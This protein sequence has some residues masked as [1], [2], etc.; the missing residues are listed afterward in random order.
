MLIFKW[1][2]LPESSVPPIESTVESPLV[3][4]YRT[5]ITP[6]FERPPKYAKKD[7]AKD[8]EHPSWLKIGFNITNSNSTLDIE[9][10]S[11]YFEPCYIIDNA[12]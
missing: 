8:G 6:H 3:Y 2:V 12:I 7:D 9:V 5:K 10:R 1:I 4:A 11:F